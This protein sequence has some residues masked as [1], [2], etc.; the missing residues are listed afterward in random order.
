MPF[1]RPKKDFISLDDKFDPFE[2]ADK[3]DKFSST[4]A[5]EPIDLFSGGDVPTKEEW[6]RNKEEDDLRL[7]RDR[8]LMKERE[9]GLTR[10]NFI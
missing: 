5:R 3:P 9:S 6:L 10:I 7:D 2:L 1:M 8:R 4:F